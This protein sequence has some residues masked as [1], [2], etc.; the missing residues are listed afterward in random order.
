M[1]RNRLIIGFLVLAGLLVLAGCATH[2]ASEY[3]R[4]SVQEQAATTVDEDRCEAHEA[5]A[6]ALRDKEGGDHA[7][8]I[9]LGSGQEVEALA[10]KH[11]RQE[12]VCREYVPRTEADGRTPELDERL[13]DAWQRQWRAGS[14]T[15][16]GEL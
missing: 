2:N 4:I 6:A 12:A 14:D 16:G 3:R 11:D 10:S 15:V 13:L 1:T 5:G 9:P 7:L 8:K